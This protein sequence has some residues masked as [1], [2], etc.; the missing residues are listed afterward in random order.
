VSEREALTSNEDV[1]EFC[2]GGGGHGRKSFKNLR[3]F[4]RGKRWL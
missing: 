3:S 2:L 1:K 4:R